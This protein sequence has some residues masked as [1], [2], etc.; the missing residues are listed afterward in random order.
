M[1]S[2]ILV[3]SFIRLFLE[4]YNDKVYILW[5]LVFLGIIYFAT[6]IFF[7]KNKFKAYAPNLY[8]IG[9][10]AVFVALWRLGSRGIILGLTS[11][12]LNYDN[13]T[14]KVGWS[15]L[16]VGTIYLLIAFIAEKL[17]NWN[18]ETAPKYKNWFNF[19][20]CLWVLGSIFTLGVGGHKPIYETLLLIMSLSFIFGSI[21]N[22]TLTFLYLGTMFLIVYIFSIGGEYF[23]NN[24]QQNQNNSQHG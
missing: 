21:S 19:V 12:E 22:K 3:F 18:L 17:K 11:D 15:N 13:Y 14:D 16:I 20:G 1:G 2:T 23:Q 9:A 8:F 7:E 5:M 10:G 24:A 6:G 4:S